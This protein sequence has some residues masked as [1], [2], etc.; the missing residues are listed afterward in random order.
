MSEVLDLFGE[1]ALHA[2]GT[3]Y[4][5]TFVPNEGSG[6]WGTVGG[7]G[8][9][10]EGTVPVVYGRRLIRGADGRETVS[11]LTLYVDGDSPAASACE[12][13]GAV[14]VDGK[15][16]TTILRADTVSHSGMFDYLAVFC[17]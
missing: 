14:V 10:V 12:T 16:A 17:E 3:P 11:S 13:G 1:W 2:D 8:V 15:P 9:T 6:A 5:V 7:D 4:I